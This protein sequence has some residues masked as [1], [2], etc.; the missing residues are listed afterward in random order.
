MAPARPA[1]VTRVLRASYHQFR[2]ADK[3]PDPAALVV[4]GS[5]TIVIR[6]WVDR[7]EVMTDIAAARVA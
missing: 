3:P 7:A 1:L 5:G 4:L 6:G 2:I